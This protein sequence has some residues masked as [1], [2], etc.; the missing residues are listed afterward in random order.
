[1]IN[2][3]RMAEKY[4]DAGYSDRNANARVCQDIVLKAIERSEFGRNVTVKGGVVM[5]S[6]T[7]NV[8][9]ATE[10]LDLDFIRYSLEDDSIRHFIS[11][12]NCLDGIIIRIKIDEIEQ[13]SQ[14]EYSGKR[15]FIIISDDEGNSIESKIDLGV[16]TNLKIKQDT[17]C[18]DV[19]MDEEGASLLINSC[20]QIFTEKL[21]SL[22]RFGPFSTRY[23]DIFDFCY[24]KN[25]VDM[26][27]LADCIKTYIIDEPSMREKDIKD[28]C[29]RVSI[30]FLNRRFRHNVEQSG[31][32]NWLQMD[33]GLAF[34]MIQEFLET[35]RSFM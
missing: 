34:K 22:L 26:S 10:D 28:I 19:C 18:F 7:G 13:L 15:V 5:R 8:R 3:G 21:R 23:K 30:T 14:Q 6:L 29:R 2:L 4:R 35:I 27:R 11:K 20:E 9:R 25:H 17:Y 12:L 33:V 24:L 31:D 16:H 1:M 32:G